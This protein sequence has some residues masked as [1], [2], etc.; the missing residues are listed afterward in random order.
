VQPPPNQ[1]SFAAVIVQPSNTVVWLINTNG[2]E[3]ATNYLSQPNQAFA[4]SGVIGTDTY[5]SATRNFNGVMDEVAVF[6]YALTPSEI[7][8]LYENGHELAQVQIGVQASLSSINLAWPQ[9]TLFQATNL[10][11]P[12]SAM[13]NAVSPFTIVPTNPTAFFRVLLQ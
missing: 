8:Q 7:Q 2:V 13:P 1:W 9:G 5:S 6:N 3:S 11:G 4:G 12:W 10:I